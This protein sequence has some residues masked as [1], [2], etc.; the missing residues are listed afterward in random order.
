[1]SSG[2]YSKEYQKAASRKSYLKHRERRLAEAKLQRQQNPEKSREAV[3]RSYAKHR[4]KRNA[5]ILA[6]RKANPAKRKKWYLDH[7]YRHHEAHLLRGRQYQKNFR[8]RLKQEMLQAY[9]AACV[10]CGEDREEFLTLD[11]IDGRGR[12]HGK[13]YAKWGMGG[14]HVYLDLR[15]KGW[16]K[17]DYRILCMNC[18]WAKRGGGICPH[19]RERVSLAN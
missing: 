3:R 14:A 11:H 6:Y 15:R 18:N 16:P 10:C 8:H 1:M 19:E 5:K 17:D 7:Y 13:T 2:S 12:D 9:G 4:T